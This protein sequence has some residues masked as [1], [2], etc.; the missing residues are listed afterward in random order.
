[1]REYM[2]IQRSPEF[3]LHWALI[4]PHEKQAL[5]NHGQSLERLAQ[6][7]GLSFC[8]AAAI[9]EDRRWSKI[10]WPAGHEKPEDPARVYLERLIA[11]RK[12]AAA[13]EPSP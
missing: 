2:P 7:G 1:M 8:E 6:R 9:L 5:T 3:K 11:A 4:A 12:Q 10:V 13:K